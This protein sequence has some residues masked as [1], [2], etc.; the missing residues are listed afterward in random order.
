MRIVFALRSFHFGHCLE[1]LEAEAR[2]LAVT[3]D[4]ANRREIVKEVANLR[5]A[6]ESQ[7]YGANVSFA[8]RSAVLHKDRDGMILQ[9]AN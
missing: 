1:R 6:A 7:S 8:D 5:R 9:R 4:S 3:I 2:R